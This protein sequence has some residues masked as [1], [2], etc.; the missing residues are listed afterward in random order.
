M[1]GRGQGGPLSNEVRVVYFGMRCDFSVAPLRALLAAGADVRAVVLPG[2]GGGSEIDQVAAAAGVPRREISGLGDPNVVEAIAGHRP[3][4]I[5]V[6]CFP[7][8]LP[9]RLLE[10]PALGCLNVH[11]SLLPVGRGPEPVFWTLRRGERRTGATIHRMDGGL[12]T[13]PIIAQE[14]IDVPEGIRAP[15]LENRLSEIG[16]NLLI[17]AVEDIIAGTATLTP[18]DDALATHAPIPGAA[19]FVVPTNLPARWAYNFVRGAASLAGP[20]ELHVL[21]TR[22]RIRLRDAVDYSPDATLDHPLIPQPEG[23]LLVQFKPGTVRLIADS[24]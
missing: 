14:A 3:D 24:R 2:V 21:A 6:A 11:P 15:E 7:W 23:S 12:D 19:D 18:Q 20:L 17:A 1:N 10:V 13:G 4:L 8:K 22:E 16:A 5:V 9:R